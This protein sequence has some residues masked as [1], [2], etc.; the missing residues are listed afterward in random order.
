MRPLNIKSGADLGLQL[1]VG[2]AAAPEALKPV[3]PADYPRMK[4]H[5]GGLW[6]S[7]ADGIHGSGWVQWC[8]G[9]DWGVPS[10]GLW[11]TSYLEPE[12]AARILT[13][14]S[15]A[16]LEAAYTRWPDPY[17]TG[18]G[19]HLAWHEV[20]RDFDAVHLTERGQWD[21]RLTHPLSLYG[22]DC[23]STVWFR[24]AFVRVDY[25]GLRTFETKDEL[26]AR[27]D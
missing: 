17:P 26:L 6:T 7:T 1:T 5:S 27:I 13:I 21:T 18:D 15:Y 12:P 23:E 14:N 9:E 2:F 16:D 3:R 20:A 4:P 10:D 11:S 22:W 8:L 24:W 19:G 25:L